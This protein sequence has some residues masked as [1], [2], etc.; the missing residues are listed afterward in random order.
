MRR[1]HSTHM[2]LR[3]KISLMWWHHCTHVL[4]WGHIVLVRRSHGAHV[5]VGCQ[6]VSR[7][8]CHGGAHGSVVLL[9]GRLHRAHVVVRDRVP[10]R[11][12]RHGAHMLP[13]WQVAHVG[14]LNGRFRGVLGGD[15]VEAA[16]IL[17][18]IKVEVGLLVFRAGGRILRERSLE[19]PPGL[20]LLL[21]RGRRRQVRLLRRRVACAGL[22]RRATVRIGLNVLLSLVLTAAAAAALLHHHVLGRWLGGSQDRVVAVGRGVVVG[23]QLLGLRVGVNLGRLLPRRRLR[24]RRR[25]VNPRRRRRRRRRRPLVISRRQG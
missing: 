20:V 14:R 7:R 9:A 1:R 17:G 22:R 19:L 10:V 8:G 6:V 11:G 12:R 5:L 21:W 23:R 16:L 3:W 13:R 18:M 15:E 4:L 2:L 25:S 24:R